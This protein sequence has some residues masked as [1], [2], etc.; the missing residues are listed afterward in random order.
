MPRFSFL[1]FKLQGY[2]TEI[3]SVDNSLSSPLSLRFHS[4]WK[5]T[6][7]SR[8]LSRNTKIMLYYYYVVVVLIFLN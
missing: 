5:F 7:K 3:V 8:H 2:K 4:V 1:L 6:K